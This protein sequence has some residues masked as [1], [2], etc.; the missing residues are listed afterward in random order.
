MKHTAF[1]GFHEAMGAKMVEFAGYY[2]PIQYEGL[3]KEH[4]TVREAVGVFDVSHMGEVWVNGPKAE[5]FVQWV[6]SNDVTAL[7][8]GK[9]QYS[10]FPNGKGGI[11]DDLLVYRFGPEKYLLVINAANIEKDWNWLLEQSKQFSLEI[12]KELINASDDIAQLAIQG[13]LALK[14]MQKLTNEPIEDMDYYTFKELTFAG[15]E[16]IFL[17][18][19]G[20]T[21]SGGCEI[22]LPN[23]A[24]ETIWKAVFE[25]GAEFGIKPIGLGARDTLRLEMGFC[26]YGND[27]TDSTSP[28]EAGLGWITKF[29]DANDF[30]DK[31]VLLKQKEE[32]VSR[33]LRGFEMIDKGIPRQ[34]YEI[35]NAA[36][37]IIGEVT[38]GTMAPAVGKGIGMGYIK[39]EFAKF[40]S[41]IFIRIRNKDLKAQIVKLP[42][43]KG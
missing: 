33:R 11:V 16:N 9:V 13:P 30:I 24:A 22:Y 1:T 12:G 29:S 20:Y 37:E 4:M 42:F 40:G 2:M 5:K 14:A 34:H 26:L 27:I 6:T 35:C 38:S 10:C 15:V 41:E 32:G 19:T 39:D 18:T 7:Y 28:I 17:S 21:G 25:A 8:D 43:Y 36:G 31:A 23:D 3:I